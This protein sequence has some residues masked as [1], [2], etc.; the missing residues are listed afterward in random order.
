MTPKITEHAATTLRRDRRASD[1]SPLCDLCAEPMRP[2]RY[3][4]RNYFQVGRI[5]P[6]HVHAHC[7]ELRDGIATATCNKPDCEFRRRLR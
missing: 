4:Y 1:G 2:N 6:I 3:G 5:D 7:Q